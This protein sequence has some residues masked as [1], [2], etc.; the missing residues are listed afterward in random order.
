[1][2]MVGDGR[3]GLTGAMA[4]D[5]QRSHGAV[6]WII[7]VVPGAGQLAALGRCG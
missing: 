7:W 4:R 6:Q 1:M 3:A 2:V 5:R